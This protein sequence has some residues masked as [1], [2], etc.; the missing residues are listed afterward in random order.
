M[1][2]VIKKLDGKKEGFDFDGSDTVD[3]CKELLAEK[4]GIKKAQVRLIF[5]GQPMAD[6]KTLAE[7]NVEAG[8]VIHM[9][10]QMRGGRI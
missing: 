8:S 2:V 5:Q 10:L 6:D 4:A 3:K 9:I 7:H 1:R